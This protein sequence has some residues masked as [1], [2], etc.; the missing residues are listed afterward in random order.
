MNTDTAKTTKF[1]ESN[2]ASPSPESKEKGLPEIYYDQET[3]NYFLPN[4]QGGYNKV[5]EASARDDL[6][7][8]GYPPFCPKDQDGR[9]LKF[10]S[11]VD[12][13]LAE[14][15]ARHNV[16]YAGPL[17]GKTPSFYETNGKRIL[18][19]SGPTLILGK[20]GKCNTIK[21]FLEGM[22]GADNVQLLYLFAWLKVALAG[23]LAGGER[24]AAQML[25]F[26]GPRN[27]GKSLLQKII[28]L[29]FGGREGR[30]YLR[31]AGRTD[32]NRDL[33]GSEHQVIE[34]EAPHR[35][36]ATRRDFGTR[37]KD[38]TVNNLV[39]CHGKGLEAIPLAPWWRITASANDEPE[40]LSILPILDESI[41]DK[42]MI[43]KVQRPDA[44]L[45]KSI[46]DKAAFW[47][48]LVS[49]LPAF[50]YFLE[51]WEIPADL[52]DS[53]F[54]VKAYHHQE[55]ME[56]VEGLSPEA[57]MLELIDQEIFG[58]LGFSE[59]WRG[60]AADLERCLTRSATADA[61]GS[62]VREQARR[63]LTST[64]TVGT[65]LSRLA[66]KLPQRVRLTRVHDPRQ[67]EME[68]PPL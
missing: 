33:I 43:F 42:I 62:S 63:L 49:E 40:N 34:D 45:P 54:G 11:P 15:R 10:T 64:K 35:D 20:K 59:A 21:R 65:Y 23:L 2:G 29:L 55:I 41:T 58:D 53:R 22:F 37:I 18:V 60:S 1:F 38:A 27:C 17:G 8:K 46:A 68:P 56:A 32:F 31:M 12:D 47:Q 52:I 19:T 14:I 7:R 4:A 48:Q 16:A 39:H 50:V 25:W 9:L 61:I 6:K 57:Q 26:I 3:K 66:K 28:T 13:I 44:V 30:P 67:Y 51:K 24:D 5:T 36:L